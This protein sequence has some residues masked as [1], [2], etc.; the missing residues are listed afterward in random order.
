[1][2]LLNSLT[3][4][5][6]CIMLPSGTLTVTLWNAYHHPFLKNQITSQELKVTW[7]AHVGNYYR[8]QWGLILDVK[9]RKLPLSFNPHKTSSLT[10][11]GAVSKVMPPCLS[12]QPM[13][14]RCTGT[15]QDHQCLCTTGL[16]Q[17]ILAGIERTKY[18]HVERRSFILL[19]GSAGFFFFSSLKRTKVYWICIVDSQAV[20]T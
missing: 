5:L 4:L 10:W 16:C 11:G 17:E 19:H 9:P 6:P 2:W 12:K 7:Q 18:T 13:S 3:T 14:E 1:M 20:K 15:C 8:S